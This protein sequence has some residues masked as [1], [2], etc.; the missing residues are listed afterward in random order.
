MA[1]SL[2]VGSAFS[3]VPASKPPPKKIAIIGAGIT[4]L[5]AAWRLQR[6]GMSFVL[7]EAS[8][9]PGGRIDTR[10]PFAS[11]GPNLWVNP[12]ATVFNTY[13]PIMRFLKAYFPEVEF[14]RMAMWRYL[15]GPIK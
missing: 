1:F 13:Q 7:F 10:T 12:F 8:S 15:S 11:V 14:I 4:G 2:W 5:A 9:R 3:A 6:A